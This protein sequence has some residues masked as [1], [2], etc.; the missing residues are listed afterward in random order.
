VYKRQSLNGRVSYGRNVQ[1][2][3]TVDEK[4]RMRFETQEFYLKDEQQMRALFPDYPEAADNTAKIAERCNF[5]FEFGHYHLPRFRLPE[6]ETDSAAYLRKLCERG[7]AVRYPDRPEVHDQL[8]YELG[9]IEKMGFVDY[10]LIVWDFIHWAKTHGIMVGPGRGS[11]AGSIVAYCLNITML[12]PLKYQLLFERFLN[13]ERVTMPDI[14]IDFCYERRGEVIDYVTRKYGQDSVV[15]IVTFGT[16]QARG[17]IRDVDAPTYDEA[18]HAQLAEVSAQ[19]KYH[20][21]EELLET[22]DIWEVK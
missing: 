19:K 22:N 12:D 14:D 15:Q 4:N 21:F 13:P 17:V 10:F 18:V 6:G 3:K 8:D 20:N 2:G 9:I 1:T 11:G 7:F 16:L 5:D